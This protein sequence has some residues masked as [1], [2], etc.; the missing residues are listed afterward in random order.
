MC[1]SA[2][3]LAVTRVDFGELGSLCCLVQDK[4]LAHFLQPI[5]LVEFD[6]VLCRVLWVLLSEGC[7]SCSK[8]G[9]WCI[10]L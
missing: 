1:T 3:H 5:N 2:Q 7:D 4:S 10:E 6:L 8:W 9:S